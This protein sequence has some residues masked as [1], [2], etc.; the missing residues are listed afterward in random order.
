M[1]VRKIKEKRAGGEKRTRNDPSTSSSSGSSE[2]NGD[3]DDGKR[4][5]GN[6]E[7]FGRRVLG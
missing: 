4:Q 2:S 1:Q 7:G 6:I 3:G 5:V